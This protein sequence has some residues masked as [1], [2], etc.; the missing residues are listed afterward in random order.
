VP[1]FVYAI[2]DVFVRSPVLADYA[3]KVYKIVDLFDVS[4]V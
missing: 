1:G 4:L 2:L 3:A